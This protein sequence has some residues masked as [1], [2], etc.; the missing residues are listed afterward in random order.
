MY[1]WC[2]ITVSGTIDHIQNSGGGDLVNVGGKLVVGRRILCDRHWAVG[3]GWCAFSASVPMGQ[4]LYQTRMS[5]VSMF[6]LKLFAIH[7]HVQ[8]VKN[9][10]QIQIIYIHVRTGVIQ[11]IRGQCRSPSYYLS[12]IQNQYIIFCKNIYSMNVW[13]FIVI[14]QMNL[15]LIN[16]KTN[17]F[18]TYGA[19]VTSE[20]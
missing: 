12:E 7:V 10:E 19:I 3:H 1:T 13:V 14:C 9:I 15:I 18:C 16:I 17:M 6:S 4:F 2:T 20:T 5:N 8:Q 11:K